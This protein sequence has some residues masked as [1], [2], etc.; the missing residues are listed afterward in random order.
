MARGMMMLL[1]KVCF[2]VLVFVMMLFGGMLA[3]LGI[4]I[5]ILIHPLTAF[6]KITRNG[7][8]QCP[9]RSNQCLDKISSL[10]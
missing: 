1:K 2:S 6:K 7:R 3:L 10:Y 4:L 8:S 9:V 5:V